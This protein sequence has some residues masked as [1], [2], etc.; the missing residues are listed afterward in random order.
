MTGE[1]V[2]AVSSFA[3]PGNI[4]LILGSA[5]IFNIYNDAASPTIK[6]AG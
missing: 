6:A 3:T 1:L 4:K 5:A 2:Q